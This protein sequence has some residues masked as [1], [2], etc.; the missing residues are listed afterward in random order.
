MRLSR[1]PAPSTTCF[2]PVR[3]RLGRHL[4]IVLLDLLYRRVAIV[5]HH[6]LFFEV[7][8][9]P[10]AN[11]MSAFP[12][13]CQKTSCLCIMHPEDPQLTQLFAQSRS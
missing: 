1:E 6:S 7:F 8:Y 10:C 5:L 4:C 12:D 13:H 11:P 2:P 9:L 3:F